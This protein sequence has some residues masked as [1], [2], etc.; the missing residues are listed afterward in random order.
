LHEVFEHGLA[1]LGIWVETPGVAAA[2]MGA[3]V[4]SNRRASSQNLLI[5]KADKE[6][7]RLAQG[8]NRAKR[9]SMATP[10]PAGLENG[11][12]N[13]KDRRN[14]GCRQMAT[15]EAGEPIARP[16]GGLMNY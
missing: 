16:P 11:L 6:F 12:V 3:S 13:Q 2:G 1:S 4:K 7:C 5:N 14:C 15:W 10:N 8:K 9:R